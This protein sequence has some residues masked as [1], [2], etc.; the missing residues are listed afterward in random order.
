[1]LTG[2]IIDESFGLSTWEW[3]CLSR[4]LR[5]LWKGFTISTPGRIRFHIAM[6][7]DAANVFRIISKG[8]YERQLKKWGFRKNLKDEEW[9]S[10]HHHVQKRRQ[11]GKLSEVHHWGKLIPEAKCRKEFS[12][13]FDTTLEQMAQNYTSGNA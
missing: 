10:I 6:L 13:H 11:H 9:K 8:V 4:M 3:I 2:N 12:R 1:M 7:S 5:Q